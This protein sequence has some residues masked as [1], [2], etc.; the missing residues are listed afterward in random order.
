MSPEFHVRVPDTSAEATVSVHV[1]VVDE[2]RVG[3]GIYGAGFA[4][5]VPSK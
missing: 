2:V 3:A 4:M 5:G 1:D